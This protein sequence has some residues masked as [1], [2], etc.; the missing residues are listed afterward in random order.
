[1][2]IGERLKIL[3]I[4][5]KITQEEFA[6]RLKV[7]K[8]FLS[9]L[10]KGIR[11]PS[12]QLLKLISYEFS[13]SENW[14]VNGEG[15]MFISPEEALKR[16]KTRL[17]ERAFLEAVNNIMKENGLA[18]VGHPAHCAAAPDPV[19]DRMINVLN[20]V[21]TKGDDKLKNWAEVQFS[22]SFPD[23]IVA[24]LAEMPKKN[25]RRATGGNLPARSHSC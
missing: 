2:S 6:S 5:L 18:V 10:E 13:S 19:L 1:M 15:E 8:G 14:L 23:E 4:S 11:N 7:S 17:G 20:D 25:P 3:R 16:Q 24:D 12:D 21:W 9:N 22:H